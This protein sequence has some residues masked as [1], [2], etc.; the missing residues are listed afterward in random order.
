MR[1]TRKTAA[2]LQQEVEIRRERARRQEAAARQTLARLGYSDA[3]AERKARTHRLIE[4]GALVESVVGKNLEPYTLGAAL[5]MECA[6][7]QTIGQMLAAAYS[8]AAASSGHV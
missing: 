4:L 8:Q 6:P 7:G 3:A 5:R 1:R 2:E